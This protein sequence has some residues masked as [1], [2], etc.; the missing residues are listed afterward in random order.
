MAR[1]IALIGDEIIDG[2]Y[3]TAQGARGIEAHL[4]DLL[5]NSTIENF[6]INGAYIGSDYYTNKP[7]NQLQYIN[8][9][10][11]GDDPRNQYLERGA[12]N[13]N[14]LEYI[15]AQAFNDVIIMLGKNDID[16]FSNFDT[17]GNILT[18]M[19]G[20]LLGDKTRVHLFAPP[21][22]KYP[23]PNH[24]DFVRML[25][26]VADQR[27]DKPSFTGL[28]V[29]RISEGDFVDSISPNTNGLEKIAADMHRILIQKSLPVPTP[30]TPSVT[31]T[32]SVTQYPD[33]SLDL[34]ASAPNVYLQWPDAYSWF[35]SGGGKGILVQYTSSDEAFKRIDTNQ[36]VQ[37]H[38]L[39]MNDTGTNAHVRRDDSRYNAQQN[40]MSFQIV[41]ERTYQDLYVLIAEDKEKWAVQ[42]RTPVPHVPSP[43]TVPNT[44]VPSDQVIVCIGDSL[45]DSVFAKSKN[46][47]TSV[48]AE[49]QSLFNRS[50]TKKVKII[51][52]A[53]GGIH[54]TNYLKFNCG[55]YD[56]SGGRDTKFQSGCVFADTYE[57]WIQKQHKV[58]DYVIM[59]GTNDIKEASFSAYEFE[60]AATKLIQLCSR[61]GARIFVF[62]PPHFIPS[63]V[64][65][66]NIER[67][68]T[69]V[70]EILKQACASTNAST[71]KCT[72]VETREFDEDDFHDYVHFDDSGMQKLAGYF[73]DALTGALI[74]VNPS[75]PSGPVLPLAPPAFTPPAFTTPNVPA[76]EQ[77]PF[78]KYPESREGTFD[79]Y[80]VI[81]TGYFF[82][83][84]NT[85]DKSTSVSLYRLEASGIFMPVPIPE[86][87][88][89]PLM[90]TKSGGIY[91]IRNIFGGNAG[92]LQVKMQKMPFKTFPNFR[93][94]SEGPP[95]QVPPSVVLPQPTRGLLPYTTTNRDPP[96][97]IEIYKV[98]GTNLK[99]YF[100]YTDPGTVALY[101]ENTA[102]ALKKIQE[103]WLPRNIEV[104]HL[105]ND[106]FG[107]LPN[108]IH[109]DL[110]QSGIRIQR[111]NMHSTRLPQPE[112]IQPVPVVPQPVM[113]PAVPLPVVP[114]PVVPQPVPAVPPF[115]RPAQPLPVVPQPVPAVPPFGRPAQPLPA[116][117]PADVQPQF[118]QLPKSSEG[119]M[120]RI[121]GT[122]GF[123][124]AP[125]EG[126]S[127]DYTEV[128]KDGDHWQKS[129]SQ[130][131]TVRY[132]HDN[133]LERKGQFCIHMDD[134]MV[135]VVAQVYVQFKEYSEERDLFEK[136]WDGI[137]DF[138]DLEWYF[139][140]FGIVGVCVVL[141]FV[142]V[143]FKVMLQK[144]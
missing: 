93:P 126:F 20:R 10:L 140:V 50:S 63:A 41:P 26:A 137:K 52:L 27:K 144:I 28:H 5:P 107:E 38:L 66:P 104:T 22:R 125:G 143:C 81:G 124:W 61:G 19:I 53:R 6:G 122:N 15:L 98:L 139:I 70:K 54:M 14:L 99:L 74:P 127:G 114:L 88:A 36:D 33:N 117:P 8:I 60:T 141:A 142:Y 73:H 7:N 92:Y 118:V 116:V 135:I 18:N 48:P 25:E 35:P 77:L 89:T 43:Y 94:P 138:F 57:Q 24:Q 45:I 105:P 90:G 17:I 120:Y 100:K 67:N 11:Q 64:P 23:H 44:P 40:N 71:N 106:I 115:G 103:L 9:T 58:T 121:D 112:A 69:P 82:T 16:R 79:M 29:T 62:T 87:Y 56:A 47:T 123:V 133:D 128:V 46:L 119:A 3:T 75:D 86:A 72:F 31:P 91:T 95:S 39:Y 131:R 96:G 101:Q 65:N 109:K 13:T 85:N 108:F 80:Q 84:R 83:Y 111:I 21:N 76:Q 102:G 132:T 4:Q 68:R 129:K 136:V 49:L 34:P 78:T 1:R 12:F 32:R 130:K 51:D 134:G 30:M 97:T 59:L 2:L 110:P 55:A 42:P 37:M 113:Q